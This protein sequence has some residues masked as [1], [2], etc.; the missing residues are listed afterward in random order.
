[1]PDAE[2][3]NRLIEQVAGAPDW[4]SGYAAPGRLPVF[5]LWGPAMYLTP[6]GDVV[7]DREEG[8]PLRPAGPGKR[9]FA[10]ARAAEQHPQLAHLKPRRPPTATTC[11]LCHGHGRITV[12][13]GTL[14]PWHDGSPSSLYCP[15]CNS[16]GWITPGRDQG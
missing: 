16:L 7:I 8:G 4:R 12:D 10:L 6:G 1:M 14:Q 2:L 11:T 5:N 9:D 3:I 15:H 13:Q